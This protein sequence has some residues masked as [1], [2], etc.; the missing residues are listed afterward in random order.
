M[1]KYKMKSLGLALLIVINK[2]LFSIIESNGGIVN[3][4]LILIIALVMALTLLIYNSIGC[5]KQI[6]KDIMY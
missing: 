6:L 2:I 4:H 3:T 1:K 5:I